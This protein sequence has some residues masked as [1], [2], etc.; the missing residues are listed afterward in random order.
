MRGRESITDSM[1]CIIDFN[2]NGTNIFSVLSS[3]VVDDF[4]RVVEKCCS[5]VLGSQS[6]VKSISRLPH[7]GYVYSY[8]STLDITDR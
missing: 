1:T 3:K 8:S 4:G 2:G 6:V 5:K 7:I